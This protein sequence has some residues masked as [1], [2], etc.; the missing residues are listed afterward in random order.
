M[1]NRGESA[2]ALRQPFHF[3]HR[4]SHKE[5]SGNHEGGIGL[6]PSRWLAPRDN[7]L[8]PTRST[9]SSFLLS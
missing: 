3:D 7:A 9:F 1:V 4:L 6:S 5:K 2:E 8:S